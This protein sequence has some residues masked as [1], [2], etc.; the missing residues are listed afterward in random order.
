MPWRGGTRE[1]S[2]R[3]YFDGDVP[4]DWDALFD[5]ITTLEKAIHSSTVSI[6]SAHGYA[7]G[8]E[9]AV[10][11]KTYSLAGTLVATGM[12]FTPGECAAVGRMATTKVSSKN[13]AVFV[14][15]YFHRALYTAA[16]G[17]PDTLATGHRNAIDSYLGSWQTGIT[18]GGRSFKRTTPDGHA[19]TGHTTSA[20]ISHRDFPR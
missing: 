18:A 9:V 3:Y 1:Y 14:F 8:S 16:S 12:S 19:T 13:H 4:A 20:Y 15:S 11:N 10:A 17:D 5:A 7:P 6:T 2:N